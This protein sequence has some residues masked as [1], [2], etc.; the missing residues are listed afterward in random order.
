VSDQSSLES[1]LRGIQSRISEATRSAGRDDD[2]TLIV[3]TKFHPE[4]LVRDLYDLGIRNVGENRHQEASAKAAACAD[5]DVTWHFIG[6][7]QS[8]KARAALEYADVIHSVDRPSLI[9]ALDRAWNDPA[10]ENRAPVDCFLQLNL[11]DDPGRGGVARAD[12]VPMAEAVAGTQSL[13]L[14]GVM[15]VAP[16]DEDP[17]GAFETVARASATVQTVVPGARFISAGMSHDF[18]EAIAHG[19]TH[20]RIGTAITGNRPVSG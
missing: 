12:L 11:T 1:R 18:V 16:L 8:N 13:N 10:S 7:L 19:A 6:Q 3:V 9:S 20:L 4:Q 14:L 2:V 17:A 15:A 5:L